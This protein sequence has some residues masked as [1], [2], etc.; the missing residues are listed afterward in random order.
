MANENKTINWISHIYLIVFVV[1]CLVPF[2]LLISASFTSQDEI[3][4]R[5]YSFIPKEFSFS[6]YEYLF[7]RG[8]E[9]TRAYGVSIFITIIGTVIGLCI[10]SLLA[11]P[12]ARAD[13]P[14]RNLIMFLVFFTMLF[15]GGL[16]P[17]YMIYTQLLDIKNTIWALIIPGLLTN[18]FYILL[19]RTFFQSIPTAL[20]ESAQ[21]DGAGEF[22]TF[23]KIIIPLSTPILA[24][25][26]MFTVIMYWNDWQNGMVYITKP[27]FYSIQNLLN[28]IMQDV[29]FISG[30]LGAN[31]GAALSQMPKDAVKMAMAV[32]G[33]LPI[34]V[35]YPF[36]Q[37]YFVK[38]IMIGAVKG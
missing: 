29:Q 32:I 25:I 31:A 37:K 34:L 35:A 24:T 2:A 36:F 14:N 23:L 5:G 21:L 1:I 19:M 11:Y 6:A 26:G 17:T 8:S 28:R 4:A 22:R 16:V 30:N 3:V 33:A 10:S 38:G 15:N 7:N 18:G 27:E 12:L 9:I 13:M 20:I